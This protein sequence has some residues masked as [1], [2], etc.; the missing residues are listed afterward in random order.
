MLVLN[1]FHLPLSL[2]I[3]RYIIRCGRKLRKEIHVIFPEQAD[4]LDVVHDHR[5]ALDPE[6]GRKAPIFLRVDAHARQ[7]DRVHHAAA[8][9]LQ[10]PTPEEHVHFHAGLREGEVGGAELDL[11]LVPKHL[12]QKV[13]HSA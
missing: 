12:L 13:L 6:P 1:I 9:H 4:V 8:Q 11:D 3:T 10:P 5:E 2:I 7:H